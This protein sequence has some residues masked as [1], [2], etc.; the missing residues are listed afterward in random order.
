M[1]RR[2]SALPHEIAQTREELRTL[3]KPHLAYWISARVALLGEL[4]RVQARAQAGVTQRAFV[5][6]GW[7]TR[8]QVAALR[9]CLT[10][11]SPSLVVEARP[12]APAEAAPVLLSNPHPARPFETLVR[13]F[14]LPRAGTVDPTVLLALLLPLMFGVMVGDVVYGAV[15]LGTAV[16][17]RHRFGGGSPILSDIARILSIASVWAIVFGF[18]FGEALG[19]FGHRYLGLDAV[20]VYRAS[21]DAIE[22]LFLLALSIGGAHVVLG[23]LLGIR[24]ASR[25]GDRTTLIGRAATLAVIVGV[26]ALAGVVLDALPTEVTA[27]AGLSILLGSALMVWSHGALGAVI[28][29]VELAGAVANVLSYLRLAAVGLASA[30][31]ANVA[32]EFAVVLPL[33]VGL[34]V[35]AVLHALNL[36]LAAFSPM[37][38]SLRLHYVEFFSKFYVGGG[39]AFRP[40]GAHS[41]GLPTT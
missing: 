8:E 5:L 34:V 15:L 6:A 39:V 13:L 27:A 28:G 9:T 26:F 24:Q 37:I 19:N 31:L 11:E 32:N 40:F 25:D 7:T 1:E 36:A 10:R 12:S 33:A 16:W 29:P 30:Y 21:A 23:L 4:E 35:A 14:D 17:L 2:L 18:L 3:I 22:P 20:W 38:Q 41:T